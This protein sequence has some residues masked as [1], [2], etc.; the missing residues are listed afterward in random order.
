MVCGV[1]VMWCNRTDNILCVCVCVVKKKLVSF[2]VEARRLLR[3][4]TRDES[5]NFIV[6]AKIPKKKNICF[7][8]V[9]SR[10][11]VVAVRCTGG[12]GGGG[13]T[14]SRF[15]CTSSLYERRQWPMMVW[16]WR[17][18]WCYRLEKLAHA[19]ATKGESA[20]RI[21]AHTDESQF[22]FD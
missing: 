14:S 6:H 1:N 4:K 2:F 11:V 3:N 13:R 12:S 19:P 15:A 22:S 16:W 21:S 18:W 5:P 20:S 17:W 9:S 10:W 8:L 7:F